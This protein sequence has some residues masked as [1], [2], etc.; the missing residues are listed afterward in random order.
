MQQTS[1]SK[2]IISLHLLGIANLLLYFLFTLIPADWSI[3]SSSHLTLFAAMSFLFLGT[4]R[5][6]D[7]LVGRRLTWVIIGWGF[8]FRI[9]LVVDIT[10][11][12][13]LLSP[14]VYRY[15]WE[16]RVVAAGES[17]YLHAPDSPKLKSLQQD[18]RGIWEKVEH[19][20]V[21]TIYPPAAQLLFSI[22]PATVGG[23]RAVL[24][25]F[26]MT[27]LLLL[28][29]WLQKK[30]MPAGRLICYAWLPLAVLELSSSAHVDGLFL[31]FMVLGLLLFDCRKNTSSLAASL[32]S[33]S[34]AVVIK[35]VALVPL[36]FVL[37]Q[38]LLEE[39]DRRKA[40]LLALIPVVVIS[41]FY[42]PF[43]D[44]GSALTAGLFAYASRWRFNGSLFL[45]LESMVSIFPTTADTNLLA[46]LI[47]SFVIISAFLF[48]AWTR[49][50]SVKASLGLF[51]CILLFS[52]TVYPWYLLWFA[53]LLVAR[54]WGGM[55]IPLL[56]F[57]CTVLLSYEVLAH[58]DDW[59]VPLGLRLLE[60]GL[61][62]VIFLLLNA[63]KYVNCGQYPDNQL[64][65]Q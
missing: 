15:L 5:R 1:D 40:L 24:L 6:V 31:P 38:L 60:Y 53:P 7:T 41:G 32:L 59:T 16:G 17:P 27:V 4:V 21:P 51:L 29:L 30:N 10:G 13:K 33:L 19:K 12:T 34:I 3:S 58:P 26:D 55:S 48:S 56:V 63:K 37:S 61:P 65:P 14:D 20:E 54:D 52:P 47:S 9:V 49:A 2:A 11:E 22:L 28:A 8:L 43:F 57:C 36:S 39:K 42:I 23:F 35:F 46:R 50:D 62:L 25:V 44:S 18:Y 45:V 64:S